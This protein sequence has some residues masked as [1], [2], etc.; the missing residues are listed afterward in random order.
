M[1]IITHGLL[2]ISFSLQQCKNFWNLLR[3]DKVIAKV[4]DHSF[5]G[6]QGRILC[7]VVHVQLFI[8]QESMQW[9]AVNKYN[10]YSE[11]TL[12]L[13]NVIISVFALFI[14]VRLP[15]QPDGIKFS[16]CISGQNQHFRPCMKNCVGSKSDCHLLELSVLSQR[17][18]SACKVWGRSNY[19][20]RL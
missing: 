10:D 8:W 3:F 20:R 17:S 14:T 13:Q 19:A 16:Q 4:W 7:A 12:L 2:E 18:L 1:G 5:F 11:R 15:W 6:T 9:S